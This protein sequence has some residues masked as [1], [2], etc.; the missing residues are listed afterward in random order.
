MTVS[1]R[2]KHLCGNN[3]PLSNGVW[4]AILHQGPGLVLGVGPSYREGHTV[5]VSEYPVPGWSIGQETADLFG[6][7]CHRLADVL[8]A[9]QEE[10][11]KVP[12]NTKKAL[13]EAHVDMDD[14]RAVLRDDQIQTVRDFGSFC[15]DSDG[16]T[17][18]H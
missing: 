16:I 1:F 13:L 3:F 7:L 5:Y 12:G 14:P 6:R 17:Y 2:E 4:G 8:R 18:V 9:R 15:R 11:L 10:W